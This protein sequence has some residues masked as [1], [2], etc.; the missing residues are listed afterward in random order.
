MEIILQGFRDELEKIAGFK[1]S[2]P[3][4]VSRGLTGAGST[5]V[6][7]LTMD[8]VLRDLKRQRK[9]AKGLKSKVKALAP[10]AGV[11]LGIGLG[12]GFAEKNIES[13]VKKLLRKGR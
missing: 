12:K 5:V 11:G 13:G 2:L 9:Q 7:G 4:A 3:W 1:S 8:K 6:I 10:L